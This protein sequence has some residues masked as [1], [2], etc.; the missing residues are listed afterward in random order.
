MIENSQYLN[1][2]IIND[3]LEMLGDDV[4]EILTEFQTSALEQ[5]NEA[6]QA[7][8]NKDIDSLIITV[9]SMKG[10]AG[11]IGLQKIYES[12]HQLEA[13]LRNKEDIDIE[14]SLNKIQQDYFLTMSELKVLRLI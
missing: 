6:T 1:A 11:N 2:E 5:I 13:S 9:H 3:L 4:G 8:K 10:A 14:S 7:T 12:C